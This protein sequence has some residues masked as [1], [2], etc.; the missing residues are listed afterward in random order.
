[1]LRPSS[2]LPAEPAAIPAPSRVVFDRLLCLTPSLAPL[3]PRLEL[4]AAHDVT[5][6]LTGESGTGKTQLARLLHDCSA[7][8]GGRFLAVCCGAL[9]ADL[10]ES[11]LFGHVQGA[12]T[13]AT[14]RKEGKFAA[15]GRGTILLDE[16]DTL[17][18]EQQVKLLR[19]VETGE[20]EPV[21]GN[22]TRRC[23]ARVI[24]SSNVDLEGAVERGAFR[25]DLYYRL[26]VISFDLPP[27]RQRVEDI[28]PLVRQMVSR[29]STKFGKDVAEVHADTLRLL[30]AYP[31]PGNL[32]ELEHAVLRAILT[33]RGRQ[34]LPAD[35]QAAGQGR[36]NTE[37]RFRGSRPESLTQSNAAAEREVIICTLR[38]YGFCRTRT[39]RTLG[40]SRQALYVK[41]KKYGLSSDRP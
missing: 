6:L 37:A 35:L 19:V 30:E 26:N 2:G 9:A 1:M 24:A 29:L 32:R 14:E 23:G 5:V 31:W 41:M 40:I 34:L 12:F 13:G 27:L 22:E 38:R 21:G 33:C 28:A 8:R 18:L 17:G 39:A 15:A 7:R 4:A 20:F 16:I 11:E 3:V 36:G 10:V 25:S